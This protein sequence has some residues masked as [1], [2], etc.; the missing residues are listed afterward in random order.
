MK[1]K[2]LLI[3]VFSAVL[4]TILLI[5]LFCS[6]RY[7]IEQLTFDDKGSSIELK[8]GDKIEIK[9]ESNPSTGYSWALSKETDET[10]VS[11]TSSE[12]IQT[13][14]EEEL[15]GSG[16]YEIFM[17]QAVKGGQAEIVL[18]YQR[19]W[20]DEEQEEDSIFNLNV[21]VK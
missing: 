6:C 13:E 9:L 4:V 21:T 20:E 12:F 17:F 14:K 3:G 1:G 8:K 10:I 7:T 2:N 19:P 18:L 5:T 11:L 15:V 16:G